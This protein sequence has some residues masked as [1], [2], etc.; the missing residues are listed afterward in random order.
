MN[1]PSQPRIF[2][3]KKDRSINQSPANVTH[4]YNALSQEFIRI[5]SAIHISDKDPQDRQEN[6]LFLFHLGWRAQKSRIR[7]LKR[8]LYPTR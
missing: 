3:D 2:K 7:L 5:R 8:L 1:A 4:W 6:C